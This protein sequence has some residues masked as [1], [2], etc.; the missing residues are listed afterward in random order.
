MTYVVLRLFFSILVI[1]FWA[2]LSRQVDFCVLLNDYFKIQQVSL[3]RFSCCFPTSNFTTNF[4]PITL[5][6]ILPGKG[7]FNFSDCRF[8]ST[9]V[10]IQIIYI[11]SGWWKNLNCFLV[12][13]HQS[14]K[15]KIIAFFFLTKLVEVQR[16]IRVKP[17][18]TKG[19][20][21]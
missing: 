6:T 3:P 16:N 19:S 9:N 12:Y 10:H 11:L 1:S 13:L 14:L 21:S 18:P 5:M 15:L 7:E 4:I 8:P 20:S 17:P 2:P